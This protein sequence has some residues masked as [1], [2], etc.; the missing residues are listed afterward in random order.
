[1]VNMLASSA[2]DC[3]LE[4]CSC[5]TKDYKIGICCF[6]AKHI[7]LRSKMK[8]SWL[9]VRKMCPSGETQQSS[10]NQATWA[11]KSPSRL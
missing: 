9:V 3:R 2:V 7:V 6:S 5:L 8:T 11:T 1:M 10:P 4:P